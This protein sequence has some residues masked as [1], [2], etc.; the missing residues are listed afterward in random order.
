M[1]LYVCYMVISQ[2]FFLNFFPFAI[3]IKERSKSWI[4]NQNPI[5]F[6]CIYIYVYKLYLSPQTIK[7]SQF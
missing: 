3:S 6:V 7:T 4:H 1:C 5:V 2:G